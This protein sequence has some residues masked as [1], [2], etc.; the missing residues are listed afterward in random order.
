MAISKHSAYTAS[1]ASALTTELDGL[2]NNSN[3]VASAEIDNTTD[4]N[5]YHDLTLTLAAQGVARSAG[6]TVTVYLVMALDGTNFDDVNETT[7]EV[8]AV[9]PLD[10]AVTARQSTRRDI[11][12]PPGKFKYF[13]RNTTGQTFAASGNL[14]EYRAHNVESF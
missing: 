9:F 14:L 13:V 6:A 11:P 5:L 3:T 7:A 2:T 12:V 4:L 1:I 10:A 8:A